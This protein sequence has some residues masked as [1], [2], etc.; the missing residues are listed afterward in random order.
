MPSI[1]RGVSELPYYCHS[2]GI[3]NIIISPGSRNAPL[4]IAFTSHPHLK[5]ISI[6]D[7]RSAGY[8]GLGMAQQLS[9]PVV[10]ICTSGTA[11]INYAPALA[12]AYYLK[13][14]LIAIT[15]DRPPEWIDQNDGQTIRQKGFYKNVVKGSFEMPVETEKEEDLWYFRRKISEALTV[16]ITERAGP[17]HINI[18]L[19]EPLYESLPAI[20]QPPPV[21]RSMKTTATL[22]QDQ[23]TFLKEKWGSFQKRLI[24][25]GMQNADKELSM[26]L[27]ELTANDGAVVMAENL[28]NMQVMNTIQTPDRFIASLTHQQ[29]NDFQPDLLITIGGPVVS[30]KLKKYLRVFKPL[31]HWYIGENDP[32][33]DTF[34]A[35]N[36]HIG[37]KAV[38][39]F[40]E[41]GSAE[42]INNDWI[43]MAR[44]VK[45][46]SMEFHQQLVE[47]VPF[48]DLSV[49]D[50][51]FNALPDKCNL[52]LANST[53]VRYA[54]LF[55]N[56]EGVSYFSNRGTSG[57]DGCVS[58]AAGAAMVSDKLNIAIVG[59]LAFIYDSNG[60]WN[61]QLPANLRVLVI[62]NEGGN[63]FKLIDTSPI[64]NP[65]RDFFETP[66]KVNIDKL[67]GAFNVNYYRAGT[68]EELFTQLADFFK[69]NSLAGVLHIQTSGELS[70]TVFKQYYQFISNYNEQSK[71]LDTP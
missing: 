30:K 11:M 14:P 35:L 49:Y 44:E 12:E 47:K 18:P 22:G 8:F 50:M 40:R 33:I 34:Q 29:R 42:R 5:C 31:E 16:S 37:V 27:N 24:L 63:I 21:I 15:A 32:F 23:W 56:R 71:N 45:Q 43:Q 70:A 19:R 54:Q 64:I 66:H 36:M 65:I 61:N 3:E 53:P 55:E 17:V 7:E 48:S 46:I 59:D 60:L 1:R 38:D 58:T 52:H 28:S 2:V 9:K 68:K 6:T 51:I 13:I 10:L 4:I 26:L 67:C 39:F 57:I 25:C 69:P 41:M 20:S 62:D